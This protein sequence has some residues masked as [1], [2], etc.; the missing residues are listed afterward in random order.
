MPVPVPTKVVRKVKALGSILVKMNGNPNITEIAKRAGT[1]WTSAKRILQTPDHPLTTPPQQDID[2]ELG[3][4]WRETKREVYADL[5][6]TARNMAQRMRMSSEDMEYDARDLRHLAQ[7][8][9]VSVK[10]VALVSGDVT[11]RTQQNTTAEHTHNVRVFAVPEK[12]TAAF[13][14][15]E[16]V[17]EQ[18]TESYD[19]G[20][21]ADE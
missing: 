20:E 12:D 2:K 9:D 4:N 3:D 8:Q 5:D 13:Q 10:T 15:V 19:V 21:D 17:N 18:L 14:T 1:S 16:G 11:S 7:A 6:A